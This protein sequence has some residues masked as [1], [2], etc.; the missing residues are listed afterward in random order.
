[1]RRN[2][3]GHFVPP[4]G[5]ASNRSAASF[6]VSR[7]NTHFPAE[8]LPTGQMAGG[9]PIGGLVDK[10]KTLM[11]SPFIEYRENL[12]LQQTLGEG[13]QGTV[14]LS[15][16]LGADGFQ[17]PVALKFF[18]PEP[19]LNVEEY[20][21]VMGHNAKVAS[22]VVQIQHDNLL[23]VRTWFTMNEIRVMEM[24]WVDGFDL[25]Q[26]MSNEML[27]WMKEHLS[28][29]DY[30]HRKNVVV[31]HGRKR[32]RLKPGIALTIIRDCL[33]A[34]KA[35]HSHGIVHSD[36]K[37]ANIMLKRTGNAKI[38]DLGAAFFYQESSPM[39]LCT[40]FY[41]APEI[42]QDRRMGKTTPQSDIASLGYVLIELLSG[43]TPF[44]HF[45]S[46]DKTPIPVQEIL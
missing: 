14:F 33:D 26:L 10:Y 44:E 30:E 46:D 42:L 28:S 38:I 17:L 18:S 15:E 8:T 29:A 32:P 24:E 9:V 36:I 19:F 2:S 25:H 40:P 22:R 16:R 39:R 3:P 34:L 21:K 7:D 23:D 35:L 6:Y 20:E 11:D 12:E 45:H 1:M 41:A 4:D 27:Q 13:G 43:A 31:T 37:P 5:N